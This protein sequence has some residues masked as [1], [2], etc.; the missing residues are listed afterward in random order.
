MSSPRVTWLF[1]E[2]PW[3]WLAKT[4]HVKR[5]RCLLGLLR[6]KFILDLY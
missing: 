4:R 6:S 1:W 5:S 3:R 2:S